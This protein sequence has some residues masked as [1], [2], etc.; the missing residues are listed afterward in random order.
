M[1]SPGQDVWPRIKLSW[2]TYSMSRPPIERTLRRQVERIGNIKVRRGCRVLNIV[3]EAHVLAATG[4]RYEATEAEKE[5]QTEP[6]H[7]DSQNRHRTKLQRMVCRPI[8]RQRSPTVFLAENCYLYS[9]SP[10]I[11]AN[12]RFHATIPTRRKHVTRLV[13]C[14]YY[15]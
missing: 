12:P 7:H 9:L 5:N 15:L 11:F 6:A 13:L 14:P 8:G 2:P 3:S 4:I 1:T 10:A